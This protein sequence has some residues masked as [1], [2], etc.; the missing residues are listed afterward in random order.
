MYKCVDCGKKISV[1]HKRCRRCSMQGKHHP[2]FKHGETLKKHYCVTCGKPVKN[3]RNLVC[4][5][6]SSKQHSKRMK[7]NNNPNWQGGKSFEPY[8]LGWTKTYREQIRKRDGYKC[9]L[10]GCP[11]T[12]CLRK[13]HVHHKDYQK[14]NLNPS[15]LVSL[16]NSCH[17][18]TNYN[19]KK[20]KELLHV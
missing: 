14:D 10:C 13:L 9:Q 11:E 7:L 18:K 4:S 15:N 1:G 8:P 19:R 16:C 2:R 17:I 6:C 3:Y 20:W 12:E 5:K